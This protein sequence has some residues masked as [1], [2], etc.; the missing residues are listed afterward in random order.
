MP[1]LRSAGRPVVRASS[2]ASRL[3]SA[4]NLR[5]GLHHLS[6]TRTSSHSE[7][8]LLR[9]SPE[10]PFDGLAVTEGTVALSDRLTHL[11]HLLIQKHT[12]GS[13]MPGLL[14]ST[15]VPEGTA[16]AL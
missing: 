13:R 7:T 3:N 12:V 9:G 15:T 16:S 4:L 5:R 10:F 11:V 8:V 14:R 2:T 1:S 6:P